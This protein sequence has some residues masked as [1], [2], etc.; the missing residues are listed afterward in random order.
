MGFVIAKSDT[1]VF[2]YRSGSDL[3]YL[4]LYVDDIILAT[5]SDRL[6]ETMISQLQTEFPMSDLG[7]LTY[8]LGIVVTRTPSYMLLSQ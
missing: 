1:S 8:F 6:H 2:T 7:S 3:A 4:F 5:S